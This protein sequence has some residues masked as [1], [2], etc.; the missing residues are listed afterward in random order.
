MA[1]K[2]NTFMLILLIIFMSILVSIF[3]I[4]MDEPPSSII[5]ILTAILGVL[6]IWYQL[7]KEHD[8][9]RAEFIFMLNTTFAENDNISTIY[10]KLKLDRDMPGIEFTPD[11]GRLM[12]EYIMYFETMSYLINEKIVDINMVDDLFSGRFF[13]FMN[14]LHTQ[15]YQL[16]YSGI[17]ITI[18]E[19]YCNWY[20]YRKKKGLPELYPN[21]QLHHEL[22]SYF[23]ISKK[24]FLSIDKVHLSQFVPVKNHNKGKNDKTT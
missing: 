11:D 7:K 3:G 8:I 16:R 24:G 13:M 15:E 22:S 12:G 20:N 2:K 9:S 4:Y 23:N 19:L 5:T 14:H 21:H 10:K 18:F 6:A 17:M 1:V